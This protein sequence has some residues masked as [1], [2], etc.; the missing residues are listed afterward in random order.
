MELQ[1]ND[2]DISCGRETQKFLAVKMSQG[3]DQCNNKLANK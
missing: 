1:V 3:Q 2:P